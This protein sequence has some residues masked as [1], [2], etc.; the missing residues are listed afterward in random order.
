MKKSKLK[1]IILFIILLLLVVTIYLLIITNNIQSFDNAI[2]NIVSKFISEPFTVFAKIVTTLGSAYI[3]VLLCIS[4]TIVL[5]KKIYGKYIFLNL[6][7]IFLINQ[8]L[9]FLIQRQRPM[10]YNL[11]IENGFSF[12]SG[13]SMISMAIYGYIIYL[14]YKNIK[15]SYL[16]W[17]LIG[18]LSL[19]ILLIGISRIYLGVH[20]ASD[21]LAGFLLSIAY[22]I[23]ITSVEKNSIDKKI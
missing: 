4:L 5:W 11:I 1:K 23:F 17:S 14:T 20:Y 13:H 18:I 16:K 19:I 7:I 9:K 21:V 2:Y 12:P 8:S 22:L 15:N 6:G 10:G 3:L